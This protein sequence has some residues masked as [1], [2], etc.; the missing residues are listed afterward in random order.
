MNNEIIIPE[1][2]NETIESMVYEIRG[3]RVMLDF[4]LAR[5]YGY[6]T[7]NFNRQVKN[8]IEKFPNDFRFKLSKEEIEY[9]VRCINFTS[10]SWEHNNEGGRRY[11]P[12]AFTEQGIYMLMTV[13]KGELATKQSIAIIRTFKQMKDYIVETN[14]FVSTNE[15]LKL[16]NV[17]Y[18][19]RDRQDKT[20]KIIDNINKDKRLMKKQLEMIMDNFID[21]SKYKHFLILDGSRLEADVAYQEIYKMASKSIYI[22][23]DYIDIKTL[24]LLNVCA[25][26]IDI[27]IF[28]DNKAKNSLNKSFISDLIKDNKINII[29]KKNNNRVHDRFIILDYKLDLEKIYLCGS[30]SKDSGNKITTI[31]KIENIELYTSLIDEMLNNDDLITNN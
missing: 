31:T 8:N 5:I 1:L 7:K 29:F 17:V 24:Q 30:S 25:P 18:D 23:D 20:E 21:P 11:L 4:E 2:N 13:L 3:Q 26:N 9:L 22:I 14:N 15:M 10:R 16:T 19:T 28:S 6:E 12:Y 27:I